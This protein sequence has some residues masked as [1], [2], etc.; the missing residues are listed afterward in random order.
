MPDVAPERMH[1]ID[2]TEPPEE[3]ISGDQLTP[4]QTATKGMCWWC[5]AIANSKEHKFKRTD[6]ARMGRE[7]ELLWG[8][9]DELVRIRSNRKSKIVKF[10]R[11]LCTECNNR[12]S[13][14]FDYAYDKYADYVWSNLD[15]LW[16]RS[17]LDMRQVF[18][19]NWQVDTLDLARYV[20][21]HIACR[22]A[23][24]GYPV[25]P[26]FGQFL[27]GAATLPSVHMVLFKDPAMWELRR[28][29]IDQGI[30][31]DGLWM[32]PATGAASPSRGRLTMFSSSFTLGYIGFMYRWDE[33]A[34]SVDPFYLYR[35]AT[36]H[37]RDR[38]PD[39]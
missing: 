11:N 3:F 27:D 9:D 6:L 7:S 26:Q 36:L 31:G 24:D 20:A 18:G 39:Q 33:D 34:S 28:R 2:V 4:Y 21:K 38:L 25:P 29:F 32:A 15:R 5:G 1:T 12:R 30:E 13:Q 17:K 8:S 19:E 35:K 23:S 37:R 14:P 16:R 22:M 10:Q